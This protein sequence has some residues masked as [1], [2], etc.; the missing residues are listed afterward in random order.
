MYVYDH[1]MRHSAEKSHRY[2]KVS[3]RVAFAV[4]ENACAQIC[5]DYFTHEKSRIALCLGVL[6]G[7]G[8]SLWAAWPASTT[9][10]YHSRSMRFPFV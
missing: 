10:I 7:D 4:I 3:G 8:R 2:F 5:L 6:L 9:E 1:G